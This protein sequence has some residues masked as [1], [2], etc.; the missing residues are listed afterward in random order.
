M[1]KSRKTN[2]VGGVSV[3]TLIGIVFISF[4]AFFGFRTL[5]SD[6]NQNIG[7]EALSAA[8]GALFVLLPTKILMDQETENHIEGQKKT[9]IF[10]ESLKAYRN[11]G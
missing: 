9:M 2:G 7:V 6:L 11:L 8:F 3:N 4:C 1:F 10:N 5:F